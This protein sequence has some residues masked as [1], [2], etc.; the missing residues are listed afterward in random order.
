MSE[1]SVQIVMDYYNRTPDYEAPLW[2]HALVFAQ[3]GQ[4]NIRDLHF[5]WD[6]G[7]T[8]DVLLL[9]LRRRGGER[10]FEY[11]PGLWQLLIVRERE[12]DKEQDAS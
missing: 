11:L 3:N 10:P 6:Y 12:L 7:L 4:H 2:A 1:E 5:P 8:M 9:S